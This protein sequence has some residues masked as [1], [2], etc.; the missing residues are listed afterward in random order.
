MPRIEWATLWRGIIY[1]WNGMFI[2]SLKLL[3]CVV[4]DK[5]SLNHTT[6]NII[7]DFFYMYTLKLYLQA[8]AIA[9]INWFNYY[10]YS[11]IDIQLQLSNFKPIGQ[12]DKSSL[13]LHGHFE[14]CRYCCDVIN[15][16]QKQYRAQ[17]RTL[18]T[19]N[20]QKVKCI[21][22]YANNLEWV[23]QVI[24]LSLPMLFYVSHSAQSARQCVTLF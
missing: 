1:V 2:T 7:S 14:G 4:H 12:Y 10:K 6:R 23:L 20:L 8:L 16:Y 5:S 18:G 13:S 21:V 9:F 15:I 3:T 24:F 17:N 19:P 11:F 22:I